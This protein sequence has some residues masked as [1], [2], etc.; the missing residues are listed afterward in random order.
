MKHDLF[1]AILF[2]TATTGLTRTSRKRKRKKKKRKRG[3]ILEVSGQK[4]RKLKKME[5]VENSEIERGRSAEKEICRRLSAERWLLVLLKGQRVRKKKK[6]KE[7]SFP[8]TRADHDTLF[9]KMMNNDHWRRE[10]HFSHD[11][12]ERQ[13]SRKR[14][15]GKYSLSRC[16]DHLE[17]LSARSP[18]PRHCR[19]WDF[20][21]L[22]VCSFFLSY[23]KR[24]DTWC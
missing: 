3:K 5:T 12:D 20:L 19:R 9:N 6:R 1:S 2:Q 4:S 21:F 18:D 10:I 11:G 7:E 15:R 17:G 22:F 16:L 8:L 23:E 13:S 14:I 24:G